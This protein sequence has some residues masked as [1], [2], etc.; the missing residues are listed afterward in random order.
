MSLNKYLPH[1]GANNE[2]DREKW[3]ISYL[4]VPKKNNIQY[5]CQY[6]LYVMHGS[7]D[8]TPWHDLRDKAHAPL[9]LV[10]AHFGQTLIVVFD[11]ATTNCT[12]SF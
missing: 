7:D 3:V 9:R 5:L 8:K 2:S 4:S 6:S 10:T 12:S 11:A 1:N